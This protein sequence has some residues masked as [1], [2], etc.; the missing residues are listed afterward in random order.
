MIKGTGFDSNLTVSCH[1][2]R[3]GAEHVD[4]IFLNRCGQKQSLSPV[5][6]TYGFWPFRPMTEYVL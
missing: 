2:Q 4:C 1:M 3:K 6:E 5:T